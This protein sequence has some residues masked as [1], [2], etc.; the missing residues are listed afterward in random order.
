MAY[1]YDDVPGQQEAMPGGLL[2]TM[3]GP[4]QTAAVPRSMSLGRVAADNA[5]FLA[6]LTALSMLANNNGRRSF[7]QL[8]GRGGSTLS[9]HWVQ[10]ACSDT[11]RTGRRRRTPSPEPNGMPRSRTGLSTDSLP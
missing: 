10:P 1:P 7:G 5:G 2:G 9:V 3:L 11:S 4:Q 8:L 6:G